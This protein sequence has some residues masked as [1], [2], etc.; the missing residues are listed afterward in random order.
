MIKRTLIILC[1]LITTQL[2][3]DNGTHKAAAIKLLEATHT[4][5]ILDNMTEQMTSMF[6]MMSKRPDISQTQKQII[7]GYQQKAVSMLKDGLRWDIVKNDFAE[8]YMSAYTENEL[9]QLT[10]FYMSPLGQ[11]MLEKTPELMSK[12]MAIPQKHLAPLRP[13]MQ[14][15]MQQMGQELSS[16][17]PTQN[18]Q[19]GR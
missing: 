3:A 9:I 2:Y 5:S 13:K 4:V 8:L 17:S 18:M 1:V 12:S 7:E 10:E 19:Q 14:Q 6:T 16:S 15:L 11:K